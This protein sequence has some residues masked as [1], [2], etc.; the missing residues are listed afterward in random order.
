MSWCK[1]K[2][3]SFLKRRKDS[4]E[5][6]DSIEYKRI[7]IKTKHQGISI[8]NVSKGIL[9]GTKL[10]FTVKEGQFLLSKID[11]R[12]GAF[13]IVPEELDGGIITGNFWAFDVDKKRVN[14]NW[15]NLFTS[16][17]N[18]YE[19]CNKASSGTTHRKYLDE[20]KFLNFEINLPDIE[21]QNLFI[22]KYEDYHK[23]FKELDFEIE[24]QQTYLQQLRQ[25]ILQE[26]VQGK[27]SEPGFAGLKDDKMNGSKKILSSTNLKNHSADNNEDAATLLKRIK[28]EKQK[29]IKEGKLKK[30]KELPPIRED[31][32]P[33]ELPKGWVWCRLG[34]IL[35]VGSSKR[36]YASDYKK[37]GVPFYR[38]MEIGQLGENKEIKIEL[39]IDEV[40]Y[41]DIKERYGIPKAG[42][43]LIACIGGSIGNTWIVDD[44]TFYYK[45]GNLVLLE[46]IPEV[47]TNYLLHYLKSDLFM[48][49]A[50]ERVLG[51]AYNA[52]TIIKIKKSLF[53]LPPLA[54]QQ[55]I[56]AKVEK[57]Q[58]Q[59][60]QLE[61][62]VQQSRE[63]AQQL[64]QAVLKEA[65]EEKG[66][67]YEMEDE[68]VG[69]VAEE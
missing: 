4:I 31:E 63:Y 6:Q 60:N 3:G 66:T 20:K 13:G 52:L 39:F 2:I 38:S 49:S 8:R 61:S 41:N 44:R 57:L 42:D 21:E 17:G 59:L 23:R 46:T 22:E 9:I 40:K 35:N 67:V 24:N 58:Q 56:V 10:Q 45:D 16:S 25:S 28:A 65:F 7:T 54:E 29:L 27:L 53:P 69:M 30:E 68:R 11:A 18:F 19:I 14:I 43:I 26:A 33:F 5:I 15:F 50:M 32:I 51:S 12:L 55:H 47:Q 48:Q 34:E 37:S 64:L 62:Q 1:V 36:I